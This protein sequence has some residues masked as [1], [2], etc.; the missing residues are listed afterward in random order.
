MLEEQQRSLA[1]ERE[2][3][4][5]IHRESVSTL[6]AEVFE[7]VTDLPPP[8]AQPQRRPNLP[9]IAAPPQFE[10]QPIVSQSPL[11]PRE[12]ERMRR[13]EQARNRMKL[14]EAAEKKATGGGMVASTSSNAINS[15]AIAEQK[16]EVVNEFF[17]TNPD[18]K[19]PLQAFGTATL[20]LL[21]F[22]CIH[23]YISWDC[24]EK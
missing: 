6:M 2:Q 11:S 3:L 5:R 12:Q 18:G 7:S 14:K 21:I 17:A 24:L 20:G 16:R 4:E 23:F 19:T 10:P 1:E 9:T 22:F 8:Q 15:P 13:E